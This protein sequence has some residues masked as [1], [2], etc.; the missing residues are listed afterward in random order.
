MS[1][2]TSQF[3]D[4]EDAVSVIVSD[5]AI[6]T[7]KNDVFAFIYTLVH[8]SYIPTHIAGFLIVASISQTLSFLCER[9]EERDILSDGLSNLR[10]FPSLTM[11]NS[12]TLY[13]AC[14]YFTSI[15]IFFC[16]CLLI[17]I[18]NVPNSPAALFVC[19]IM[20]VI[21]WVLFIPVTEMLLS[22]FRCDSN[23]IN[24]GTSGVVCYQ[25]FLLVSIYIAIM[26]FILWAALLLIATFIASYSHN[27]N[28][29]PFAHLPWNFEVIYSLIRLA[30]LIKETIS[31]SDVAG[32]IC[33]IIFNIL[34]ALYFAS[35]IWTVFPYYN[36]T[37]SWLFAG[38]AL[39]ITLIG[40]QNGITKLFH[41]FIS[42]NYEGEEI[43]GIFLIILCFFIAN[44]L[45]KK[46][47]HSL[48]SSTKLGT[49]EEIDMKVSILTAELLVNYEL[50]GVSCV[51]MSGFLNNSKKT[52]TDMDCP[53]IAQKEISV[54]SIAKNTSNTS[55][56]ST[57]C[58]NTIS[59]L[60]YLLD[61]KETKELK[62]SCLL[63]QIAR[64]YLQLLGNVH[65]SY[66]KLMEAEE[67]EP[68][69]IL[70]FVIYCQKRRII[71]RL[72]LKTQS[73][74]KKGK[75]AFFKALE[76]E[77]IKYYFYQLI[78]KATNLRVEFWN[79]LMQLPNLNT[80]HSQGLQ[81]MKINSQ[82]AEIWSKLEEIN[83]DYSLALEI[84]SHYLSAIVGASDEAGNL[85]K[86]IEQT[87]YSKSGKI[88]SSERNIFSDD[89]V[90]ILVS[91]SKPN[92]SRILQISNNIQKVL[93]FSQ[94][95]LLDKNIKILMPQIVGKNHMIAM[96]AYYQNAKSKSEG[97]FIKTFA[98]HRNGYLVR[99]KFSFQ[100][101]FSM[102][103]G[104]LY[105]GCIILDRQ[106]AE[107]NFI[108]TSND[109]KIEGMSQK[110]GETLN[111]SS[112]LLSEQAYYIQDICPEIHKFGLESLEGTHKLHF[113]VSQTSE[114]RKVS[115]IAV[116][117]DHSPR[118]NEGTYIRQSSSQI[119]V[120]TKC[121]ITTI[122]YSSMGLELKLFELPKFRKDDKKEAEIEDIKS[123]EE[124]I[125]FNIKEKK[126][127]K[128]SLLMY[129]LSKVKSLRSRGVKK[130][131]HES[132]KVVPV[133]KISLHSAQKI[134][135]KQLTTHE[136]LLQ[137]EEQEEEEKKEDLDIKVDTPK[138]AV[139]K[140]NNSKNDE[141]L[142]KENP[143]IK[144]LTSMNAMLYE[145][146][147]S[148]SSASSTKV[149]LIVEKL[150]R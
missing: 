14:L 142:L 123:I 71:E 57:D 26:P 150:N 46:R 76:Y 145:D 11:V 10:I 122:H 18:Y 111:L 22:V 17:F 12:D 99:V 38:S 47:V 131:S 126:V 32:D 132:T 110:I 4:Y 15:F 101:V 79:Q 117:P 87:M 115:S 34:I 2:S 107:F 121:E 73:E 58:G 108:L 42:F 21:Y 130:V 103:F 137:S 86:K 40:L 16:T 80:L 105:V 134:S 37:I 84:Y 106:A 25:G 8:K 36:P 100:L 112:S 24:I 35:L 90:I 45:Y 144:K 72:D 67:Q 30:L 20:E 61:N 92:P 6:T 135:E 65:I 94:K 62:N 147:Q 13:Y 3:S 149:L 74:A 23:N 39:S 29:N 52:C 53:L 63:V 69:I 54:N 64:M 128:K 113:I 125:S 127:L 88:G 124:K 82:V 49:V 114:I 81:I 60:V 78:E 136:N 9:N 93:G 50:S 97:S 51:Y 59:F 33:D 146:K 83:L 143:K 75:S 44:H 148:V 85:M 31:I 43:M 109:G 102:K 95:G 68:G 133:N 28:K 98:M 89:S 139:T 70:E 119:K 56:N 7:W 141:D 138:I 48:I 120:S 77:H 55:S 104:L 27:D 116:L 129:N 1:L 96:E 91:G 66:T 41:Q 5:K 140:P 19:E 118:A